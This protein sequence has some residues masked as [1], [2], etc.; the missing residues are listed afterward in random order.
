MEDLGK[1]SEDYGT[2]DKDVN[3]EQTREATVEEPH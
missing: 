2:M 1:D 3:K